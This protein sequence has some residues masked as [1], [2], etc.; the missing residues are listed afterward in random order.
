MSFK[1]SMLMHRGQARST[2]R[3]RM[4]QGVRRSSWRD[5]GD[6]SRERAGG[7]YITA[8]LL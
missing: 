5:L 2:G 4:A 8:T 3:G 6:A 1:V 7:R